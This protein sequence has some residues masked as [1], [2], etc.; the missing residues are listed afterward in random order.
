MS[1]LILRGRGAFWFGSHTGYEPLTRFTL[2]RHDCQVVGPRPGQLARYLGSAYGRLQGRMGRGATDM[3][4]WEMR[5]R[6]RLWRPDATHILYIEQHLDLLRCWHKAPKDLIGTIHLPASVWKPEQCALLSRIDSALVLYQ[7]DIPFF[8]HYVGKGR[9][10][11]IL[12]G[13][14]TEFFQLDAVK[15]QLPPRILYSGVYLRNEGMLV[16]VVKQLAEKMPELRFDLLVPVHHRMRP[17]LASLLKHPSVTWHAGL[18][19]EQLRELYQQSHLMLLP[20]NESGANTAIVEALASGLPIATTDVGG[21]RDY[22]GGTVFPIVANNDDDAMIALVEQ[23]LAKPCWRDEIAHKCR[24]FA[25]EA[26]AW[27]LVAQKHLQAY[28]ELTA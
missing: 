5:L 8:E 2:N 10:K 19:D 4:E 23:Y 13:A 12:L 21:I 9:I 24:Q 3:S 20:M 26:L 18:T 16:R 6:R 25:E 15:L 7:R 28:Q 14:D 11:F 22:G 17:T 27:P 1:L